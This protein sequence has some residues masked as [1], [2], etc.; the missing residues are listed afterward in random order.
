MSPQ[1]NRTTLLSNPFLPSQAI[2]VFGREIAGAFLLLSLFA[3]AVNANSL[4]SDEALDDLF[5]AQEYESIVDVLEPIPSKTV[6]Q[7]NLLISALMNTDLDDAEAAAEHFIEVHNHDFRA[8]HM[9]ANVMGA[10]ASNSVFSALGYAKKAKASLQTAVEIAPDEIAVYQALMQ[11]YVVAPSIAGGDIEEA[12]KLA[13]KIVQMNEPEG[14]FATATV[15]A[16]DGNK[17]EATNILTALSEQP[18]FEA[19]ARFELGRLYIE[20]EDFNDAI[21][22]LTP[23]LSINLAK[24]EKSDEQAWDAYSDSKFSQLYGAYRIG[25]VAVKTSQHTESGINALTHYLAELDTTDINTQQLPNRNWANLRLAEL[26]LNADDVSMATETLAKITKNDDKRLAKM[27]K[28]LKK[29]IK[30]RT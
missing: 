19:R 5:Q 17:T 24:A 6:K 27:L 7:Y 2:T 29:K 15:Y 10:Q 26:F 22:A 11:F 1:R 3:G 13:D 4:P 16:A 28:S 18:E 14:K 9:H 21:T 12:K 30:K 25:W 23:L 20:S 8:Y